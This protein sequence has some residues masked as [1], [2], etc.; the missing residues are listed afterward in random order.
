M[1]TV[2]FIIRYGAYWRS[3]SSTNTALCTDGHIAVDFAHDI[4]KIDVKI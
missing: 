2:G 4:V 1:E 3:L